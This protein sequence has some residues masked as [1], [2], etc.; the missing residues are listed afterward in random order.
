MS[1]FDFPATP[2]VGDI[3]TPAG[4]SVSYKWDGTVWLAQPNGSIQPLSMRVTTYTPGSYSYAKPA[5]LKFLLV[6]LWGGGGGSGGAAA[7][8]AGQCAGA[9]GGGGAAYCRKLYRADELAASEPLVV[10]A[11]G[12]AGGAG[13]T[14]GGNGG[15]STFKS[16]SAGGGGGSTGVA[17]SATIFA[18]TGRGG[19]GSATVGDVT[20]Q[21]TSGQ[22]GFLNITTAGARA[23]LGYGG[24]SNLGGGM[25]FGV[26]TTGQGVPTDQNTV[27]CGANGA[28]NCASQT[29]LAGAQ[30]G[31]GLAVLTEYFVDGS[32]AVGMV[33][34]WGDW[35]PDLTF[36]GN[37]VGMTYSNRVGRYCKQG[38]KMTLWF[39]FTL[40]AK[41]TSTGAAQIRGMPGTPVVNAL[42]LQAGSIGY[43]TSMGA[44]YANAGCYFNPGSGGYITLTTPNAANGTGTALNSATDANLTNTTRII[45]KVEYE[46]AP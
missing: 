42:Q 12:T 19:A 30:G 36:A 7:T 8:A 37:A 10:G 9:G 29:A 45:G 23:L 24:Q 34:E 46:V 44:G 22:N 27:G 18:H 26:T 14:T 15:N 40:S 39:D 35:T 33:E 11:G 38:R 25:Y 20:V 41:G 2:A 43:T 4:A 32:S 31:P 13:A 28:M 5:N 16:M 6:E 1:A 21:G 17:A 3:Y